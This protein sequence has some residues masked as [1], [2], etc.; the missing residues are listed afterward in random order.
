MVLDEKIV[1]ETAAAELA[2]K[3][4]AYTDASADVLSNIMAK[5]HATGMRYYLYENDK[6]TAI[7]AESGVV[8]ATGELCFVQYTRKFYTASVAANGLITWSETASPT[9]SITA[10]SE[11]VADKDMILHYVNT[12]LRKGANVINVDF[13]NV[14]EDPITLGSASLGV[15]ANLIGQIVVAGFGSAAY[16]AGTAYIGKEGYKVVLLGALEGGISDIQLTSVSSVK[17]APSAIAAQNITANVVSSNYGSATANNLLVT[18]PSGW[19]YRPT[20]GS[21]VTV[22]FRYIG[23]KIIITGLPYVNGDGSVPSVGSSVSVVIYA[24]GGLIVNMLK[25]LFPTD[26]WSVNDLV[27]VSVA[28]TLEPLLGSPGN[29]ILVQWV[30]ANRGYTT[31][32]NGFVLGGGVA[33][34]LA[35]LEGG[36]YVGDLTIV[37]VTV[38][39]SP[40]LRAKG[41][42]VV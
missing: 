39:V 22:S 3:N 30:P 6:P 36:W 41:Y 18:V 17:K 20:A 25:M 33:Y 35:R 15:N 12:A 21:T 2:A 40:V 11:D 32:S 19:S 27:N 13:T 1:G 37:P 8:V 14:G 24:S 42:D 38:D 29:S 26:S 10:V 31:L 16:G 7:D 4:K 5:D 9:G 34:V 28:S 23:G